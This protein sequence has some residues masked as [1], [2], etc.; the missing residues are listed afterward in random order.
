MFSRTHF[1]FQDYASFDGLIVLG[2]QVFQGRLG[3]SLLS[4][5]VVIGDFDVSQSH[6]ERSVGIP[7][8]GDLFLQRILS[9]GGLR[10]R[11]LVFCLPLV[12]LVLEIGGFLFQL[13]L[14]LFKGFNVLFQF[15]L[16]FFAGGLKVREFSLYQL[17]LRLVVFYG[18]FE[19]GP[20]PRR[21]GR[22]TVREGH[23]RGVGGLLGHVG[24]LNVD[25][26]PEGDFQSMVAT[27]MP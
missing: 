26:L 18:V 22:D 12:N 24:S 11:L 7:E 23:L 16:K 15:R 25:E 5:V 6:V 21:G 27:R 19:R 14:A 9:I 20:R 3:I 17:V 1:F 2:F 13:S 4:L 10:L 8:F